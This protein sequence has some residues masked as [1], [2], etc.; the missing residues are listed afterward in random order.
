MELHFKYLEAVQIADKKIDGEK[1]VCISKT[2]MHLL[3]TFMLISTSTTSQMNLI[4]VIL[5][6]HS[7][8]SEL[9]R[10]T[11]DILWIHF[12]WG[13]EN[14]FIDKS[15]QL[16][17]FNLFIVIALNHRKKSYVTRLL[18]TKFGSLFRINVRYFI[19]GSRT[20]TVNNGVLGLSH[21]TTGPM[22]VLEEQRDRGVQVHSFMKMVSKVGTM[23]KKAFATLAFIG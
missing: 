6:N 10:V 8:A 21:W 17:K 11:F 23:L 3:Q 9:Y 22:E 14:R 15:F 5:G 7:I 1:H 16:F 19:L 4:L 18:A 13:N 12:T 20:F 2:F